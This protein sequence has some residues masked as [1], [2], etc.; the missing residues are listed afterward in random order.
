MKV[1]KL[2]EESA[3]VKNEVDAKLE[4]ERQAK[5]V[6]ELKL[7]TEAQKS[8]EL[9]HQKDDLERSESVARENAA[10]LEAE[11]LK[12]DQDNRAKEAEL[13]ALRVAQAAEAKR[14]QELQAQIVVPAPVSLAEQHLRSLKKMGLI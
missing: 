14:V 10:R 1:E 6:L 11:K 3:R 7:Q 5:H 8:E 13:T 12:L 9:K 2:A 4:L